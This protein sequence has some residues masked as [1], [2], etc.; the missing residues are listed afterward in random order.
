M[1]FNWSKRDQVLSVEQALQ[2]AIA[3]LNWFRISCLAGNFK[4]TLVAFI[5]VVLVRAHKWVSVGGSYPG[6]ILLKRFFILSC[7]GALS[8]WIRQKYPDYIHSSWSSSGVVS[9]VYNFYQFDQQ[10]S[11]S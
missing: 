11:S 6:F 5:Y 8:A 1:E 2:D 3:F 7:I 9:A 4:G 10:V